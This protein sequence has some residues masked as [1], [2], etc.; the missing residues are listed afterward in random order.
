MRQRERRPATP[1]RPP[2]VVPVRYASFA[3]MRQVVERDGAAISRRYSRHLRRWLPPVALVL[4]S[5]AAC[6]AASEEAL[7]PFRSMYA[8]ADIFLTSLRGAR[9]PSIAPQKVSGLTVPH[10][11]LAADLIAQAFRIAE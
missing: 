2:C 4:A 3:V 10:H 8:D 5:A 11:L 1:A 6:E 9:N 7:A